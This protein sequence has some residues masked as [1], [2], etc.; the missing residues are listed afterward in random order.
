MRGFDWVDFAKRRKILPKTAR[1]LAEIKSR[2]L[3]NTSQNSY[4]LNPSDTTDGMFPAPIL[5]LKTGAILPAMGS[6]R[7]GTCTNIDGLA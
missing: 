2:H 1:V 3:P 7:D 6:E 4:R 5:C